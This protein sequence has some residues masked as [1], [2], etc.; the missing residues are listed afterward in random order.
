VPRG[1]RIDGRLHAS[2]PQGG[3]SRTMAVQEAVAEDTERAVRGNYVDTHRQL[4][5][6]FEEIAATR[7]ANQAEAEKNSPQRRAKGTEQ[8]RKA[9]S[10]LPANLPRVEVV[11][12][13]AESACPCCRGAMV[14]IGADISDRLDVIPARYQVLV[15]RRPIAR[16]Q[17]MRWMTRHRAGRAGEAAESRRGG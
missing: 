16:R 8:R 13:P 2:D 12:E 9:R 6:A 15:T 4:H 1:D 7:A 3:D 14:M 11:I 17:G 10:K 5:F